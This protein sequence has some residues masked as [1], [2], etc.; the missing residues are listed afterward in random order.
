M[1]R[2]WCVDG[3]LGK[4]GGGSTMVVCRGRED[5]LSRRWRFVVLGCCLMPVAAVILA[6]QNIRSFDCVMIKGALKEISQPTP[7]TVALVDSSG[8]LFL[9]L[10]MGLRIV[11]PKVS[12]PVG[13]KSRKLLSKYRP[14]LK[15][16][17][18]LPGKE[19]GIYGRSVV[20]EYPASLSFQALLTNCTNSLAPVHMLIV[21]KRN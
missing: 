3:R 11:E 14:I 21:L 13:K 20:G 6:G 16:E 10:D 2:R 12:A 7:K 4:E 9:I 19:E 5:Q 15:M 17:F 18:G 1:E 8:V